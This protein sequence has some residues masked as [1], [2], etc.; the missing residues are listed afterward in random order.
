MK[1]SICIPFYNYPNLQLISDLLREID[2]L[3]DQVEL[4]VIDD[5]SEPEKRP[6]LKQFGDKL[7]FIQLAKN[8]GRSRIRNLFLS[9]TLG[10]YLLFID[11]D[12]QLIKQNFIK[13]YLETF[14]RENVDVIC[15]RSTYP[16]N[17]PPKKRRLRWLYGK[18]MEAQTIQERQMSPFHSFMTNNFVIKRSVF[19]QIPFEEKLLRYGHEDTLMGFRLQQNECSLIHIDNPVEN[20]TTEK[21]ETYLRKTKEAI[22]NL[23][24]I[25]SW[26]EEK[27]A[28]QKHVK[29]ARVY[30]KFKVFGVIK[31]LLWLN[32]LIGKKLQ[33]YLING[34]NNLVIFTF[35]KLCF[36]A[37]VKEK[38]NP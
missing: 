27:E 36:Y 32:F 35:W 9:H 6:N 22:Q 16:A 31:V 19:K 7:T 10:E 23:H 8:I 11:G 12:S 2:S 26:V 4:V 3:A 13:T 38:G 33:F 37:Q 15:G 28:F 34:G 5:A 21:N 1:L 24:Y 18:R 30:K 29:L 17:C 14:E 20:A 25:E